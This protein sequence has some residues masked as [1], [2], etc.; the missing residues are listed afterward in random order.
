[1]RYCNPTGAVKHIK[2]KLMRH[3]GKHYLWVDLPM[4]KQQIVPDL[5]HD[6]LSS[7]KRPWTMPDGIQQWVQR[8]L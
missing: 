6:P 1:M 3:Q 4:G 2:W 5:P 8:E 7:R